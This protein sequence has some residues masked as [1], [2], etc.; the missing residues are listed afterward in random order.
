MS[1]KKSGGIKQFESFTNLN[2]NAI[3]TDDFT[4]RNAY[5]GTFTINGYLFVTNDCSLNANVGIGE[6]VMIGKNAYV[7][8]SIFI[9]DNNPKTKLKTSSLGLGI[10]VESPLAMLDIS[11]SNSFIM[12]VYSSKSNV[13]STLLRNVCNDTAGLVLDCCGASLYFAVS[14]ET[15]SMTYDLSRDLLSFNRDVSFIGTAFIGKDAAILGDVSIRKNTSIG[16]NVMISSDVDIGGNLM[17]SGENSSMK[18][19]LTVGGNL[20]VDGSATLENVTV[21]NGVNINNNLS[22]SGNIIFNGNTGLY[23]DKLN[24]TAPILSPSNDNS[25]LSI[26]SNVIIRENLIIYGSTSFEGSLDTIFGEN[27]RLYDISGTK[28]NQF[29]T[30][31]KSTNT[32]LNGAGF[33]I[34][35]RANI[36]GGNY[37]GTDVD[38]INDDGFMKVSDICDNKL[39]FRSVGNRNV[40][41]MDLPNMKNP[42]KSGLLVLKYATDSVNNTNDNYN[43]ISSHADISAI[44]V[45]NTLTGI[46][47]IM[48]GNAIF[49]DKKIYAASGIFG[50]VS[51]SNMTISDTYKGNNIIL[52]FGSSDTDYSGN[53]DM[54]Q[55][56]LDLK[57]KTGGIVSSSAQNFFNETNTFLSDTYF[58]GNLYGNNIFC[59]GNAYL[60]DTVIDGNISIKSG[61]FLNNVSMRAN[62]TV[63]DRIVSKDISCNGNMYINDASI[64][65]INNLCTF[66]DSVVMNGNLSIVNKLFASDVSAVNVFIGNS[67]SVVKNASISGNVFVQGTSSFVGDVSCSTTLQVRGN[68]NVRGSLNL[69]DSQNTAYT[70]TP[71]KLSY[72]NNVNRDIQDQINGINAISLLADN[73]FKGTNT[74][75][76][77]IKGTNVEIINSVSVIGQPSTDRS[78][79]YEYGGTSENDGKLVYCKRN[80]KGS[81]ST[82]DSIRCLGETVTRYFVATN[83]PVIQ[84]AF[85]GVMSAD[86]FFSRN[87]QSSTDGSISRDSRIEG[88]MVEALDISFNR[89]FYMNGKIYLTGGSF[90]IGT[91]EYS[92]AVFDKVMSTGVSGGTS[93]TAFSGQDFSGESVF[94]GNV[95]LSSDSGN[96][97]YWGSNEI[98]LSNL[99]KLTYDVQTTLDNLMTNRNSSGYSTITITGNTYL[100]NLDCTGEVNISNKLSCT[101]D[102]TSLNNLECAGNIVVMGDGYVSASSFNT[103]SDYRLKTDVQTMSGSY[104]TVDNLRPVT[105]TLKN[106]GRSRI[107]FIAHELQE[108]VPSAVL[109]V[110]DA[111][112]M[113]SVNYAEIIPILVKE[114]QDMKREIAALKKRIVI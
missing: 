29:H 15:I 89:N 107:G 57:R 102:L 106:S 33:Y 71:T 56:F 100:N 109:G 45:S 28:L 22:L 84:T 27:S 26:N 69:I 43:I 83:A 48:V 113:Q 82:K 9:G 2:V 7:H 52:N 101:G 50:D 35:N 54:V 19:N 95:K 34:Y 63:L 42:H 99:T 60:Q 12:N 1:W 10:N 62:L 79:Y 11:G 85:N 98:K 20:R 70:V 105:Y 87:L 74:F 112:T 66:G 40:V 77:N 23:F 88:G 103:S 58:N 72:L 108:H 31:Y 17:V 44:D 37:L 111:P 38:N 93:T 91:K 73:T 68:V 59:S 114:I 67:L 36:S 55:T 3:S 13:S 16:G 61:A 51:S 75:E 6:N 80:N 81:F 46:V 78:I 14:G 53:R 86:E 24:R 92:S 21:R 90:V 30:S 25:A 5:N 32:A 49:C 18:H 110:K 4:M 64:R 96:K 39:S 47:D 76:G 8:D 94:L 41:A 65:K 104:Y 97:F